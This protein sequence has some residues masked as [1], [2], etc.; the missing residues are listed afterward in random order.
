M[1]KRQEKRRFFMHCNI[2]GF[3]YWDGC[4]ALEQLKVGSK[5]ELIPDDK[6]RHDINAVAIYYDDY[7]LGYIPSSKAESV[8]QFFD[9]GHN[10]IFETRVSRINKEEHPESQVLINIYIKNKNYGI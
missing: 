8:R 3:T 10:D 1:E 2:A 7:K 4:L 9:M 5:L 6:N